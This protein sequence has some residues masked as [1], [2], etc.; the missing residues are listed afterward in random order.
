MQTQVH[1][2]KHTLVVFRGLALAAE[3]EYDLAEGIVGGSGGPPPQPGADR[4]K[5]DEL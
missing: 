4:N 5:H 2:H 1:T 3:S